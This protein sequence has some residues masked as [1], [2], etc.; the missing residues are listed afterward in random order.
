[1]VKALND[2]GV[3]P[4]DLIVILQAIHAAGGLHA[5]VLTL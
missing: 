3:K 2:M 4:R 1:M 5:E